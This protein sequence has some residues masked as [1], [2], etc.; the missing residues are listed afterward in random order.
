[1]TVS[2]LDR[3]GSFSLMVGAVTLVVHVV[4]R[5]W[6]AAGVGPPVVAWQGLW[7]PFNV[8]GATGTVLVFLGVPPLRAR[9]VGS[10]GI[11]GL[12]ADPPGQEAAARRAA[13]NEAARIGIGLRRIGPATMQGNAENTNRMSASVGDWGREASSC[14]D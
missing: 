6:T 11:T 8:L 10:A 9:S 12:V 1:M 2:R 3:I 5:F 14:P 13:R 4:P 7:L